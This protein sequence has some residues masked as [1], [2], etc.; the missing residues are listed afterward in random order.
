M[1]EGDEDACFASH[2][3][4]IKVSHFSS[5]CYCQSTPRRRFCHSV[6]VCLRDSD[7]FICHSMCLLT[8]LI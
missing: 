2:T 3:C 4:K 7:A 5:R 6:Q 8:K 1:Q